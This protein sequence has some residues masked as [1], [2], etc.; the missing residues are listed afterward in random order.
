MCLHAARQGRQVVAAFQAADDAA[1]G[2]ALRHRLD[3]VGHPGV[4]LLGQAE[5]AHVVLAVGVKA[6][7]DEDHLGLVFFQARHPH[8]LDQLAHV[9]ALGVGGHGA[10]D[11]IGVV[12]QRATLG[13]ERVLEEA[14][15]QDALVAGHDVLG[16]VAVVHVEVDDG[17]A[18][19]AVAL[20][21]VL[22][23]HRHV[24][25]EAEAH[26]LVARGVVAGRAGA[27]EGVFQ[28]AGNHRVHRVDGGTG[29][30]Q[31]RAVGVAVHRSVGVERVAVG[32]ASI[33]FL[34]QDVVQAA[35]RGHMAAAV[36]QQQ[37]AHGGGRGLAPVEC[38]A[39]AGDQQPVFDGVEPLRAF[40]V[41]CTHFMLAA[42]GMCEIPGF[43]HDGLLFSRYGMEYPL[44][45]LHGR[46]TKNP[47]HSGSA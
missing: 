38:V 33:H 22:G 35:Q 20:A 15:H 44:P 30:Q 10:V 29:R 17:H 16:A 2:K 3:A 11:E 27:A 42:I 40:G 45:S 39:D 8:H 1:L 41:P 21:G 43:T 12:L 34:D 18:L 6:G 5:L 19:H 47:D 36:R 46:D 25:E 9:H 23:G 7:A 32:A 26:G 14:A 28:L 13:V 31:R 24:A 4:V 37:F